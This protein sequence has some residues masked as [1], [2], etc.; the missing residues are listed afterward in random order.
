M[1]RL[2]LPIQHGLLHGRRLSGD[3]RHAVRSKIW[4]SL[5]RKFSLHVDSYDGLVRMLRQTGYS[6]STYPFPEEYAPGAS[7]YN[8]ASSTHR[9]RRDGFVGDSGDSPHDAG[10]WSRVA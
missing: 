7:S 8:E 2:L 1:P 10:W 3:G 9:R 4:A 5:E 6:A